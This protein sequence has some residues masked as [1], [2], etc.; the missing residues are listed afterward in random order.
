[1]IPSGTELVHDRAGRPFGS[2]TSLG[3]F[4]VR[5]TP[6]VQGTSIGA[7]PIHWLRD[8]LTEH[9]LVVLRGFLGF[10]S[11]DEFRDYSSLWGPLLEWDFGTVL[12]IAEDPRARDTVFDSSCIPL[13]WDAM[14][15][16]LC[17]KVLLFHSVKSPE[18][19]YG[20]RTTF[21]DTETLLATAPTEI[22][23]RWRRCSVRYTVPKI[24]HYHGTVVSPLVV[25]HPDDPAREVLRFGEP[26]D[27]GVKLLNPVVREYDH[28]GYPSERDL[29]IELKAHL[30][31]PRCLYA[32]EW[33]DGD[34]LMADNYRLLHGRE[35][36][37]ERT[38]RHLQRT[39]VLATPPHRN[40]WTT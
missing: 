33:Q 21:C 4:G 39:Q 37:K 12:E 15:N 23:E 6:W 11:A 19:Q 3:P 13:H 16:A 7:L 10:R 2:V 5:V 38:F 1:M 27:E 25:P 22:V 35:A 24:A 26:E 18:P 17:P 14:F 30:H 29:I 40:Q 9:K 20:G 31:A 28:P 36:F 32:H 34:L 8:L